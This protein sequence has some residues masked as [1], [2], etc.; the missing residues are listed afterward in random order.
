[1]TEPKTPPPQDWFSLTFGQLIDQQNATFAQ[2]RAAYPKPDK[3]PKGQ[4]HTLKGEPQAHLEGQRLRLAY[5]NGQLHVDCLTPTMLHVWLTRRG[6]ADEPPFSYTLLDSLPREALDLALQDELNL[7]NPSM[8]TH[9]LDYQGR[10]LFSYAHS[11]HALICLLQAV[12]IAWHDDDRLRLKLMSGGV[13]GAYGTGERTF[14]TNL[15][16]RK[17]TF[18]N[19]DAGSYVRGF[20][21]INTTV[22]LLILK[23]RVGYWGLFVDNSHRSTLDLQP[24]KAPI[25]ERLVWEIEGGRLSFFCMSGPTLES[26]VEQFTSLTGRMPMPP[27][28]ALGY[29]QSRYSYATQAEVLKVAEELRRRNIPCDAIHLDIHYMDGYRV[30]TW[31]KQAFPDPQAM[32][33]TLH[34]MGIRLVTILDPGV[35]IDPDYAVYQ[36]GMAQ[37]VFMKWPDGQPVAGVVWPGMTHH[38]DFTK[39]AARAWWAEQVRDFVQ[40]YEIDGLWND[41]NEPLY[42]SH[43]EAIS[44]PDIVQHDY[45]G[46]RANH[47]EAHNL[48]GTAD[49]A[50]LT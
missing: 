2:Y 17:L 34:E 9:T 8:M 40:T 23:T 6:E 10:P 4:W 47:A 19:T 25:E 18:W 37:D 13:Q 46:Q 31:D 44:P 26:I 35:K 30:F 7:L 48:Y 38:P 27:L 41:M 33:A 28:W 1:V 24:H 11:T 50:R 42:F 39:P 14:D 29:H 21:P 45:E 43:G 5:S 12:E 32:S 3:P 20:E 15:L 16:G 36:T 49:G 22:P